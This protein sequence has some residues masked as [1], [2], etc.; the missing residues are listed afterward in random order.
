LLVGTGKGVDF[1]SKALVSEVKIGNRTYGIPS[2]IR[3]IDRASDKV[4]NKLGI[5][6]F[7]FWKFEQVTGF[8]S[9]KLSE[10]D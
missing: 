9:A 2:A 3:Y 1:I 5:P 7:E 6:K 10:R 8:N 4:M